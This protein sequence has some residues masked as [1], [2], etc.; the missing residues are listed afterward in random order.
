MSMVLG[1]SLIVFVLLIV[2]VISW[3]IRMQ[4]RLV[5]TD[6]LC[7]NAM[8]QIG[9]QQATRWDALTALADLTKEYSKQEYQVI[10][11]AIAAR[12]NVGPQTSASDAQHQDDLLIQSFGRINALAEAYPDLKSN[13][14]Y[15]KTMD[16]VREFENNVRMS[17]MVYNDTVTKFNRLIREFPGSLIAGL[18][19]FTLRD[20]LRDDPGKKD[21]PDMKGLSAR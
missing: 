6:E 3:G 2:L 15:I 10:L 18:L 5:R 21:M 11:D 7:G 1:I 8:S 19:H 14:V 20:Y 12:K 13:A 16:S 9:V 4:N 17:R